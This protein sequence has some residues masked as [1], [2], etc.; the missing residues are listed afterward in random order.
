[1]IAGEG[2]TG[3][4]HVIVNVVLGGAFRFFLTD[5]YQHQLVAYTNR[6]AGLLGPGANTMSGTP[7]PENFWGLLSY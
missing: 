1:M 4:T 6:A 3:K 7:D 2:G 5:F